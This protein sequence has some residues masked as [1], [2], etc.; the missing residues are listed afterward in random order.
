MPITLPPIS[1]RRFLAG[2][3][4]AGLAA[5]MP[6]SAFA[7]AAGDPHRIA[8][9][10]DIHIDSNRRFFKEETFPWDNL[11][12]AIG[13]ILALTPRPS[14]VLVNGDLACHGGTREDYA[15]LIEG[16]DP[17]RKAGLPIHLAM[18]NHDDRR[19]FFAVLPPDA[20]RQK[21]MANRQVCIV[22]TSRANFFMLDSLEVTAKSPG[23]L[24]QAQL[25]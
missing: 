8:L 19:N 14:L 5:R 1:R 11:Q 23:S 7:A 9:L 3:I 6:L 10:S 22:S 25:A 4:A 12:Q 16:L 21:E 2:S 13:E 18:G 17:L 24:G 15:A 20:A